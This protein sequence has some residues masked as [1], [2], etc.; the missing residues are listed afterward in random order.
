MGTIGAGETKEAKWVLRGDKKGS[1]NLEA[2]F[3]GILQ[4]FG[5][6]INAVYKTKEPVKVWGEDALVMHV[7]AED[8]AFKGELYLA[9]VELENVSDTKLYNVSCEI[10]SG[11]RYTISPEYPSSMTFE[12]IGAGQKKV[13]DVWL[14]PS[15]TG[16]LDLSE[17]FIVKTGGNATIKTTLE[18]IPAPKALL[19]VSTDTRFEELT[20]D[21]YYT[22]DIVTY[23]SDWRDTAGNVTAELEF[24][25]S[26]GIRD[27]QR[28]DSNDLKVQL[29]TLEPGDIKYISWRVKFKAVSKTSMLG[30]VIKVSG[31]NAR[32]K[33]VEGSVNAGDAKFVL[34]LDSEEKESLDGGY[35]IYKVDVDIANHGGV[36]KN[37][38]AQIEILSGTNILYS[39]LVTPSIQELGLLDRRKTVSWDIKLK[40]DSNNAELRYKV[41]V[42]A[43]N[44]ESVAKTG[45]IGVEKG[46]IVYVMTKHGLYPVNDA[47]VTVEGQGRKYTQVTKKNDDIG[48]SGIALLFMKEG[49]YNV[50]VQKDGYYEYNT[51][52]NYLGNQMC[53]IV[54]DDEESKTDPYI[55]SVYYVDS[56][57][58]GECDLSI[59]KKTIELGNGQNV[60]IE[61]IVN[62][63]GHTPG[64]VRL[65]NGS[66]ESTVMKNGVFEGN[67]DG[68][69]QNEG[70]NTY[71]IA[72]S[73]DGKKSQTFAVKLVFKRPLY[74]KDGG[75]NLVKPAPKLDM[76]FE[77]ESF[78]DR[79]FGFEL[80][81]IS[82][83]T[84]IEDNKQKVALGVDPTIFKD[85]PRSMDELKDNI[86]KAI[87]EQLDD[88]NDNLDKMDKAKEL[89]N[90]FGGKGVAYNVS[91]QK[92]DDS[93]KIIGYYQEDLNTHE[94][95]GGFIGSYEGS[96]DATK[97]FL[98]G[99]V[100]VYVA[101]GLAVGVDITAALKGGNGSIKPLIEVAP[102]LNPSAEAGV[103]IADVLSLGVRLDCNLDM[104][105][106][107]DDYKIS[108]EG[109]VGESLSIVAKALIF[110]YSRTFQQHEQQLWGGEKSS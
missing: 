85:R 87:E 100:P 44:A 34:E 89:M 97:Q 49:W 33:K 46:L 41:T 67:F 25:D 27:L 4:P 9:K 13:F 76:P 72:K 50:K 106:K 95:D 22:Y 58:Q 105:F 70:S 10:K 88:I 45:S 64:E 47:V 18:S 55:Q 110:E 108:S 96:W 107:Y 75:M 17:S 84:C 39:E 99:P 1:Y 29:G 30:Y 59:Q 54:L 83:E 6:P 26:E 16:E 48:S 91:D 20:Q 32:S 98:I 65:Y 57:N 92:R 15:F 37:A 80:G 19:K 81:P 86:N 79:S 56:F 21:N 60:K 14:I 5:E 43:D 8:F 62:W 42:T 2:E 77:A 69:F 51:Y 90:A 93:F 35:Y 24:T 78:P 94:V 38:K 103:G 36:A 101:L 102:S 61:A 109:S 82:F 28:I 53:T 63:R 12:E 74:S 71:I 52:I 31:D 23:V 104:S 11:E 3:N 66:A 7:K 40:P 73:A 68:I